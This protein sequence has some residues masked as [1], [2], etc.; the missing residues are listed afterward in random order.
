MAFREATEPKPPR[1]TEP[2]SRDPWKKWRRERALEAVVH[3]NGAGV[4]DGL[5]V[6][7]EASRVHAAE[8]E[9]GRGD[10]FGGA[11]DV[12]EEEGYGA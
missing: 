7:S 1:G 11:G 10:G 2:A 3:E 8:V 4:A 9:L 12:A 6:D 5:G